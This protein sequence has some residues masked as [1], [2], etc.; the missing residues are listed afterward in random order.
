MHKGGIWFFEAEIGI[1]QSRIEQKSSVYLSIIQNAQINDQSLGI[2]SI[3]WCNRYNY[4]HQTSP[5]ISSQVSE[6][7]FPSK[8]VFTS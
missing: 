7:K 6:E 3:A 4:A 5:L 8:V 2:N 1:S